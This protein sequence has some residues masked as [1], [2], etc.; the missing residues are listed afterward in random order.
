MQFKSVTLTL[1]TE[2]EKK[3]KYMHMTEIYEKENIE[4]NLSGQI[5]DDLIM[6]Q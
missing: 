3:N 2:L 6:E 5:N 1:R 4:Y